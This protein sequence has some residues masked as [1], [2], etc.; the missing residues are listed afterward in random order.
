[1]F[2]ALNHCA[3]ATVHSLDDKTNLAR[4]ETLESKV[5]KAS[6]NDLKVITPELMKAASQKL[7]PGKSDPLL[8]LTS[9]FFLN[10]PA[11]LYDLLSLI[12]KSFITHDHVSDFL[13]L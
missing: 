6:L 9:E 3:T 8:K 1:M 2:D 10:A 11:I 7:K 5:N 12:L 13:L 4:I